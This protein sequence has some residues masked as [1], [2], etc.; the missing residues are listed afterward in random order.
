VFLLLGYISFSLS[1]I[2]YESQ[3]AYECSICPTVELSVSM[4][5]NNTEGFLA[6]VN[7]PMRTFHFMFTMQN[8]TCVRA[9]TSETAIASNC[10][11]AT[12]AGPFNMGNGSACLGNIISN[13]TTFQLINDTSQQSFGLSYD[14]MFYMGY[15]SVEEIAAI[16]FRE[17]VT[18]FDWLVR[19]GTV[20]PAPGGEI[21]PRTGIAWNKEGQLMI[22]EVDGVEVTN[23]GLTLQQFA[24]W[25]LEIGAYNA[26]NLDGGGSSTAFY[27][28]RVIDF[29][30]CHDTP[31]ECERAV[32]TITCVTR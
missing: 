4:K 12:N 11:F 6:L 28:G 24:D 19:N 17:L 3:P 26:L 21:A 30:T 18:G 25:F 22:L 27:D 23:R 9:L 20:Y 15:I 10:L 16:G 13:G 7:D 32:T 2:S 14:G 5:F 31:M 29:P 8:G 1:A